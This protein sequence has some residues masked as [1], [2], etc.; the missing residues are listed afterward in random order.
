MSLEKPDFIG[1]TI[2]LFGAGDCV[3]H[4]KQFVSALGTLYG[5]FQ[6]LGATLVGEFPLDA[7]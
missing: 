2:A 5:H 3:T 1:K 7:R 6:K 4:G